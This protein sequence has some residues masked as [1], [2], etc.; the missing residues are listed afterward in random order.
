LKKLQNKGIE[1]SA[2]V[3]NDKSKQG[4]LFEGLITISPEQ[5]PEMMK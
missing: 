5:L 1:V 2:F 3:D 4:S